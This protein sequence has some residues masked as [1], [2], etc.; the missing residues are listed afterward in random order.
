MNISIIGGDLRSVRLVENYAAEGNT[1][2]TFGLENYNWKEN[3]TSSSEEK[4]S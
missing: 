4:N 3:T 1:I 2:Y